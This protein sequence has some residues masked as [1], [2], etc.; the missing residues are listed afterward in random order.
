MTDLDRDSSLEYY[1]EVAK[2]S[3]LRK[4][5]EARKEKIPNQDVI[6]QIYLYAIKQYI[7]DPLDTTLLPEILKETASDELDLRFAL[8]TGL[9]YLLIRDLSNNSTSDE[10][11]VIDSIGQ[12]TGENN[13]KD[14]ILKLKKGIRES[15]QQNDIE[16]LLPDY[17]KHDSPKEKLNNKDI[18]SLAK[19][20]VIDEENKAFENKNIPRSPIYERSKF[21]EENGYVPGVN[22]KS[23]ESVSPRKVRRQVLSTLIDI[24]SK[25]EEISLTFIEKHD[26]PSQQLLYYLEKNRELL[27]RFYLNDL[28]TGKPIVMKK[29]ELIANI[30]KLLGDSDT[31]EFLLAYAKSVEEKM[32]NQLTRLIDPQ[33]KDYKDSVIEFINSESKLTFI[34][35]Q[36]GDMKIETPINEVV[37]N[38]NPVALTRIKI[39]HEMVPN[40]DE[41]IGNAIKIHQNTGFS[42]YDI[43]QYLRTFGRGFDDL[44]LVMKNG[45]IKPNKG[46][47]KDYHPVLTPSEAVTAEVIRNIYGKFK[48]NLTKTLLNYIKQKFN[49]ANN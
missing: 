33:T 30:Q 20:V 6:P 41:I 27:A 8:Q 34:L 47:G 32:R 43:G 3:F 37:E 12:F 42:S 9:N 40:L 21:L 17:E 48:P 29:G 23:Y 38:I 45:Y 24:F 16:S 13:S 25:D 36:H 7:A 44:N 18:A 22:Q 1:K 28:E 4:Q 26:K 10:K 39:L 49:E 14:A 35:K 46:P 15:F 2:E 19:L 5:R 11:V 31:N